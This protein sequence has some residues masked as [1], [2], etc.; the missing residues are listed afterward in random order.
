MGVLDD[1]LI[2]FDINT[3]NIPIDGNAVLQMHKLFTR[4][5]FAF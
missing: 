5:S 4:A 2:S 3:F 1:H